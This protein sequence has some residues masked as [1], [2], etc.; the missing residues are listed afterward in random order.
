[1]TYVRDEFKFR[2]FRNNNSLKILEWFKVKQFDEKLILSGIFAVGKAKWNDSADHVKVLE[3]SCDRL[4]SECQ[5][6]SDKPPRK[7]SLT[8]KKRSF[9]VSVVANQR[10]VR[11]KLL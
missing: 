5:K 7:Q 1:M 4:A 6:A 9:G 11:C 10:A 3:V 2:Q 8:E